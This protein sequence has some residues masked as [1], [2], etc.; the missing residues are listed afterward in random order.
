MDQ[1][2]PT[3]RVLLIGRIAFGPRYPWA[4]Q[5]LRRVPSRLEPAVAPNQFERRTSPPN[6]TS[7]VGD[8]QLLRQR[9][10]SRVGRPQSQAPNKSGREQV[11]IDPAD[12]TPV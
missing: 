10:Q 4:A 7:V 3:S 11:R 8:P 2:P 6:S 12:T 5:A 9:Q 1:A